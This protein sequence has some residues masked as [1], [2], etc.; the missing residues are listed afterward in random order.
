MALRVTSWQKET[1]ERA[2]AA[3]G[4]SLTDFAVTTLMGR[5]Q[6]VLSDQPVFE[7]SQEAWDEFS[8]LLDEPVASSPGMVDL[9]STPTVLDQ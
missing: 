4:G 6:D 2:A 7:V 8:R 1:L 5:A 9:L 3:A